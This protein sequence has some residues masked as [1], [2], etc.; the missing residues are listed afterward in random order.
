MAAALS[1][2][3]VGDLARTARQMPGRIH[4]V[5]DDPPACAPAIEQPAAGHVDDTPL[6]VL[7]DHHHAARLEALGGMAWLAAVLD[8]EGETSLPATAGGRAGGQT[9]NGPESQHWRGP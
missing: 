3:S 4:L 8:A 7:L 6:V 9:A 1:G 5:S 2:A